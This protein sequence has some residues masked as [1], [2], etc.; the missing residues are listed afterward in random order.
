MMTIDPLYVLLLIELSC[1][2]VGGIVFLSLRLKKTRKLY[3]DVLKELNKARQAQ[4][5]L[6]RQLVAARSDVFPAAPA[7]RNEQPPDAGKRIDELQAQLLETQ[8]A[9]REKSDHLG[10]LQVKFSDLEK[11]YMILYHQ[12]QKQQQG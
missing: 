8:N 2:L 3:L 1:I 5:D 6:R 4:E 12:Q 7:V 11:E 10:Q 9:L